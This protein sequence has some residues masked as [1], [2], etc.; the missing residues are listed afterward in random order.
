MWEC[1]CQTPSPD[2]NLSLGHATA[3]TPRWLLSVW[4]GHR[5]TAIRGGMPAKPQITGAI[6]SHCA[7]T[8]SALICWYGLI[9]LFSP[10]VIWEARSVPAISDSGTAAEWTTACK[11]TV[12]F[13]GLFVINAVE[14]QSQKRRIN[15]KK[16]HMLQMVK[17]VRMANLHVIFQ[18]ENL[19]M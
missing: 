6:E 14:C 13:I 17:H 4:I 7:S 11:M 2:L 10:E 15:M 9:V 8:A 3:G 5:A 18:S 16:I 19:R 12:V 1:K